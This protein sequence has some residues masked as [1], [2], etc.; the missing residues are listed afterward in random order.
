MARDDRWEGKGGCRG[1]SR[2]DEASSGWRHI[3]SN[4]L[5][6]DGWGK[7]PFLRLGAII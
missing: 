5:I 3:G 7:I 2:L 4:E 6:S 1:S